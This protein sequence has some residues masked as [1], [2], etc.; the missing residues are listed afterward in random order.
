M[1][2]VRALGSQAH[3]HW[4]PTPVPHPYF[5]PIALIQVPQGPIRV[6][7]LRRDCTV[8]NTHSMP[9]TAA[10][11]LVKVSLLR[12]TLPE[13]AF[14]NIAVERAFDGGNQF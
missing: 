14:E 4:R 1:K 8:L 10:F 6:Q 2:I 12:D 9:L 5:G 13:S 3:W 11:N 7:E